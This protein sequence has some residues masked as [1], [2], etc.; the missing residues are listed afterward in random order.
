MKILSL[1]SLVKFLSELKIEAHELI[2]SIDSEDWLRK[3]SI[4]KWSMCEH[5]GHLILAGFPIASLFKQEDDFFQTFG[6]APIE[7]R[8]Y[9]EL[10]ALYM[11]KIS[12]G[13]LAFPSTVPKANDLRNVSES[14]DIWYVLIDKLVN[15]I[16]SNWNEDRLNK[17]Q[18]PHPG[19][20]LITPR[21]MIYFKHFHAQHHFKII[22][23]MKLFKQ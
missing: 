17:F 6:T 12:E 22:E 10:K 21:E 3:D 13:I 1:K 15:R 8:T 4:E 11:V 14:L 16:L 9:E 19:L 7:K 5:F 2:E 18:M 20:G 23:K